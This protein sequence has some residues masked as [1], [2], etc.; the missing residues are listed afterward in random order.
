MKKRLALSIL[1]VAAIS[2]IVSAAT[3]AL[4]TASTDNVG[5][6][7]TAGTVSLGQPA[8]ALLNVENIVPG[9]SDSAGTFEITYT[10]SLD[11]WLGLDTSCTGELLEGNN[12]L[13]VTI[14]DFKKSDDEERI[15]NN[16]LKNQVVGVVTNGAEIGFKVVYA[17]PLA[18]GNEYQGKGATV[19]L[20]VHAVQAKNNTEP[21]NSGPISWH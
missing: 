15:Y 2:L 12:P 5:N 21:D 16:N 19:S 18:A 14:V 20:T 1:A 7:F 4:F 11:A 10:G 8:N 13:Q 6:T 17:M 9:D 3:Y